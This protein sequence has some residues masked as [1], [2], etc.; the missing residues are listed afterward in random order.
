MEQST[1]ADYF[2]YKQAGNDGHKGT[3]SDSR[4]PAGLNSAQYPLII[5]GAAGENN[6]RM[7][8]SEIGTRPGIVD[9]YG[10]G[11]LLYCAKKGSNTADYVATSHATAQVA[12]L[13]ASFL[14][15]FANELPADNSSVPLFMKNKLKEIART[16]KSPLLKVDALLLDDNA[17]REEREKQR[18]NDPNAMA[19]LASNGIFVG[20]DPARVTLPKAIGSPRIPIAGLYVEID[21]V[22]KPTRLRI[23]NACRP[24]RPDY[25][26]IV[27]YG[28]CGPDPTTTPWSRPAWAE[29]TVMPEK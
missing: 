7:Y 4:V 17:P 15:L 25:A 29:P 2:L 27:D 22:G 12:G 9:L 26:V 16:F 20:C 3:R 23:E 13:V 18:E 1:P 5:V 10:F 28:I 24:S 8:W 6:T 21:F 11:D 14:T 19:P